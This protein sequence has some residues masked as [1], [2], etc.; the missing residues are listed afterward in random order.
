MQ[1][2][3]RHFFTGRSLITFEVPQVISHMLFMTVAISFVLIG[4]FV[5]VGFICLLYML[6]VYDGWF[7]HMLFVYFWIHSGISF[8]CWL[9]IL[10]FHIN[11]VCGVMFI[12]MVFFS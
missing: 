8:A 12:D 5:T 3:F 11:Y 2:L 1:E 6:E 7:I 10:L 9:C 4:S